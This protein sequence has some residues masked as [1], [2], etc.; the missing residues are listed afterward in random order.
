MLIGL[1]AFQGVP[2]GPSLVLIPVALAPIWLTALGIGCTV[3]SLKVWGSDWDQAL[4]LVLYVMLFASPVFFSYDIMPERV[5]V[6]FELNPVAGPLQAFRSAFAGFET[7]PLWSYLYGLEY[8]A[9]ALRDRR[10]CVRR[11]GAHSRGPA[12]RAKAMTTS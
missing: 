12:L 2:L 8:G 4:T 10:S 6:L 9:A 7:F 5:R 3:A 11:R 1:A